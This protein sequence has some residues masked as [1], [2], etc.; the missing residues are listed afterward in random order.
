MIDWLIDWSINHAFQETLPYFVY[1]LETK[2]DE[3]RRLRATISKRVNDIKHLQ[4]FRIQ[5]EAKERNLSFECQHLLRYKRDTSVGVKQVRPVT[6]WKAIE[7]LSGGLDSPNTAMRHWERPKHAESTISVFNATITTEEHDIVEEEDFFV[8]TN[9][10]SSSEMDN[11]FVT[12]TMII[13]EENGR[14]EVPE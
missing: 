3:N 8:T 4:K 11:F 13:S 6:G 12:E 2:M 5:L 10:N 7:P 1:R 14:D 9:S